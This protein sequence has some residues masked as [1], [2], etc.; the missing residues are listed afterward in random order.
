VGFKPP[1]KWLI[2]W[3]KASQ[4]AVSFFTFDSRVLDCAKWKGKWIGLVIILQ[5]FFFIIEA[6]LKRM[7]YTVLKLPTLLNV[8]IV[9]QHKSYPMHFNK[10]IKPTTAKDEDGTVMNCR[11]FYSHKAIMCFLTSPV[12]FSFC[13][14]WALFREA[15]NP[16]IFPCFIGQVAQC[17]REGPQFQRVPNCLFSRTNTPASMVLLIP[18][19]SQCPKRSL[20]K[21]YSECWIPI[22]PIV[23][24]Y[25]T[26]SMNNDEPN[27]GTSE[28]TGYSSRK[29]CTMHPTPE[30]WYHCSVY[31]RWKV[32]L[33]ARED[34]CLP[35]P[36]NHVC[37][38][39]SALWMA[40][41]ES[42]RLKL[43]AFAWDF[44]PSS[45]HSEHSWLVAEFLLRL[46][47]RHRLV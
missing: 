38:L 28:R 19:G 24:I 20:Q 21:A 40:G 33:Q 3:W 47:W 39:K 26:R 16:L 15:W 45:L 29:I 31:N 18:L 36:V 30:W 5:H 1:L 10:G 8:L 23:G 35:I 42:S 7:V 17:V 46:N 37:W 41:S 11:A 22:P 12:I 9:L 14:E 27:C 4:F 34:N 43:N 6:M 2:H 44:L 13:D 32:T 25:A